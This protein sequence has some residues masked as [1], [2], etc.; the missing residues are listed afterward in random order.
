[1]RQVSLLAVIPVICL[2]LKYFQIGSGKPKDGVDASLTFWS[3][4]VGA[5]VVIFPTSQALSLP[6]IFVSHEGP[7][8]RSLLL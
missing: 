3:P 2:A 4:W 8:N 6:S 1:M 7:L 5:M